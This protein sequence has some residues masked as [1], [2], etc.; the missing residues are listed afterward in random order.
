MTQSFRETILSHQRLAAYEIN[1]IT[2][3]AATDSHGS[4]VI[5]SGK[6][7]NIWGSLWGTNK[8]LFLHSIFSTRQEEKANKQKDI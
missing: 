1:K 8:N 4:E 7:K 3:L 2:L 5:L 6:W